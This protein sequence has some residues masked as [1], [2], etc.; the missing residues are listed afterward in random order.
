MVSAGLGRRV[1]SLNVVHG[2][3]GLLGILL[4]GVAN[5]AESTAA[6]SVAI[7]NHDLENAG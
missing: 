4:V 6:A 3:D 5:K 2:L 1:I 7:L